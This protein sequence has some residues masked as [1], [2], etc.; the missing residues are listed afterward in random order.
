M[1]SAKPLLWIS[2]QLHLTK[3]MSKPDR[4]LT[5]QSARLSELLGLKPYLDGPDLTV[6]DVRARPTG[7]LL[8]CVDLDLQ[9]CPHQTIRQRVIA[10]K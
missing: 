4:P 3:T 6:D 1:R 9:G 5:P 2:R 10:D 7:C 8:Q